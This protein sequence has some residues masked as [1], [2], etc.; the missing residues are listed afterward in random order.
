VNALAEVIGSPLDIEGVVGDDLEV[1]IFFGYM[2]VT[3][4]TFS[5]F[6]ELKP[7]PL[8]KTWPLTVAVLDGA[9]GLIT[10]SLTRADSLKLGPISGCPWKITWLESGKTFTVAMGRFALN[11]L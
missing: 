4:F 10:V 8:P 3:G 7:P 6:V 2:P 9:N 5:S 11:R 1:A